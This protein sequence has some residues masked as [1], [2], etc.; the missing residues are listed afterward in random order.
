MTRSYWDW[1]GFSARCRRSGAVGRVGGARHWRR[2]DFR[3]WKKPKQLNFCRQND[4]LRGRLAHQY[5]ID[6]MA[7][8]IA[9]KTKP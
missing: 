1:I 5:V 7:V 3:A 6:G 2:S 9:L 8:V 4:Q